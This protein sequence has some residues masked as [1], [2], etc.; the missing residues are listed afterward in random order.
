MKTNVPIEITDDERC[1]LANMID[2][3]EKK[4]LATRKEVVEL[5]QRHIAALIHQANNAVYKTMVTSQPSVLI[6]ENDKVY[7]AAKHPWYTPDREDEA[8]L[9]GKDPE[10]V[11]GWNKAKHQPRGNKS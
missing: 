6:V 5:C 11:F 10:Y 7:D 2:G 4:R 8:L 9:H 3:K 1:L